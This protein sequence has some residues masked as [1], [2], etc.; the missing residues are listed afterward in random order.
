M[1]TKIFNLFLFCAIS[2]SFSQNSF[3]NLTINGMHCAGGCAKAI[4]NTLNK[5]DGITAAVNFTA[6]SAS[7]IYDSEKFSENDIIRMI[8]KYRDGKFTASSST[9]DKTK[10]S[11][12]KGKNCCQKT[13]KNNP[14]CDNKSKGCCASSQKKTKAS[15]SLAGMIPG[16]AG[17]TKSCCSSKK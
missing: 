17:C 7:I 1:I 15:A 16:H 13:G 9:S 6:Q 12:S 8:N 3:L 11:C 4:E 5:N 10:N 2:F 14:T